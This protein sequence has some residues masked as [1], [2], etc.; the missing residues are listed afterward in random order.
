M[1]RQTTAIPPLMTM[2]I[3]LATGPTSTWASSIDTSL[4]LQ[5][6]PSLVAATGVGFALLAGPSYTYSGVARNSLVDDASYIDVNITHLLIGGGLP[7]RQPGET[8]GAVFM[9]SPLQTG[10]SGRV[11][12][13]DDVVAPAAIAGSFGL[14]MFESMGIAGAS[15]ST[16]VVREFSTLNCTAGLCENFTLAADFLIEF[17]E[18]VLT[19]PFDFAFE[20]KATPGAWVRGSLRYQSTLTADLAL[21]PTPVPIPAPVLL[22]ASASLSFRVFRKVSG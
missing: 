5:F 12:Q 20:F 17:G 18:H 21:A 15:R 9:P 11:P 16:A 10:I 8:A 14:V 4:A 6:G 7:P 22:L 13:R 19:N 3:A 2:L 1:T